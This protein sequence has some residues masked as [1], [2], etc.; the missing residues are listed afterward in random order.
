MKEGR[1]IVLPFDDRK[2]LGNVAGC[3]SGE[4]LDPRDEVVAELLEL[5]I[6]H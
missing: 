5:T 4:S 6:S 1:K 3:V 2:T